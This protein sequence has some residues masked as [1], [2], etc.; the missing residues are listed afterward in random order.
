MLAAFRPNGDTT[1]VRS[2]GANV[3]ELECGHTVAGLLRGGKAIAFTEVATRGD[4]GSE[5]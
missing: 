5:V 3:K 1:P 2:F 4:P